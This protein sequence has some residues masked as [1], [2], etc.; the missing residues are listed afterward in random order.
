MYKEENWKNVKVQDENITSE[1]GLYSKSISREEIKKI[2]QEI[3]AEVKFYSFCDFSLMAEV[4][5]N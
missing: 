1:D 4:T 5:E 2:V 3:N